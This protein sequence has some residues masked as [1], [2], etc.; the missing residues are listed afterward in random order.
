MLSSILAPGHY[1]FALCELVL[2]L[3]HRSA[4]LNRP[5]ERKTFVPLSWGRGPSYSWPA[6]V[7][8]SANVLATF[9][10]VPPVERPNGGM[11]QKEEAGDGWSRDAA[12]TKSH[13]HRDL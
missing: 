9:A 4:H 6:D 3:D 2:F 1:G 11:A 12:R 5:A 10:I 13:T 8:L 7:R